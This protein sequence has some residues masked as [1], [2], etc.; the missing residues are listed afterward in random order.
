MFLLFLSEFPPYVSLCMYLCVMYKLYLR[1]SYLSI[2]III[3][4]PAQKSKTLL[5]YHYN[6]R[7][8]RSQYFF[9]YDASLNMNNHHIL[10]V[11]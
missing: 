2:L 3:L 8:V 11:W 10:V 7:I 4:K 9:Q 6:L 1:V 5:I